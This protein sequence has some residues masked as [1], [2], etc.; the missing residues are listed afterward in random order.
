MA[1]LGVE[2]AGPVFLDLWTVGSATAQRVRVLS[3]T[4]GAGASQDSGHTT[5]LTPPFN[6]V[7]HTGHWTALS[8]VWAGPVGLAAVGSAG[9]HGQLDQIFTDFGFE[10]GWKVHL[11]AV[12][13]FNIEASR[14]L[15][16]VHF[17]L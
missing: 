17:G 16:G 15:T 5:A 3:T 12:R 8:D 9:S 14:Q 2:F 6:G 1:L 11:R 10:S 4:A 7:L 13:D